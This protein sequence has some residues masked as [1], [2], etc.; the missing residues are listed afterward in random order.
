[1]LK[2]LILLIPILAGV[3]SALA[4]AYP[5]DL[6]DRLQAESI[7]KLRDYLARLPATRG[8]TL[9]T[10]IKRYEWCRSIMSILLLVALLLKQII[11]VISP[12]RIAMHLSRQSSASYLS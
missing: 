6:V 10:A 4:R 8:C 7:P 2:I 12:I 9:E 11:G 5:P 3:S 1:M